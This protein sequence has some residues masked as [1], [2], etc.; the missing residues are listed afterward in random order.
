MKLVIKTSSS[1]YDRVETTP[2]IN[3]NAIIFYIVNQCIIIT[4]FNGTILR[5]PPRRDI[6]A[7]N[8]IC[9][10]IYTFQ[11]GL[12]EECIV[13]RLTKEHQHSDI[14]IYFEIVIAGTTK[15]LRVIANTIGNPRCAARVVYNFNLVPVD[16]NMGRCFQ[17]AAN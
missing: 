6:T 2:T 9:T 1:D 3:F 15:Q 11:V 12:Q 14:V 7:S 10:A 13:P 4:L 5:T 8:F 16:V 17:H